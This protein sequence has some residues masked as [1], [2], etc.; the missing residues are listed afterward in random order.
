[1]AVE[2]YDVSVTVYETTEP[3]I[4]ESGKSLQETIDLM[5][6]QGKVKKTSRT[7]S[8]VNYDKLVN[9]KLIGW[10]TIKAALDQF[11]DGEN[12]PYCRVDVDLTRV[13]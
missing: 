9:H 3:I 10:E 8:N 7:F 2:R 12:Y 4:P 13:G 5:T 1:M 6:S 11:R